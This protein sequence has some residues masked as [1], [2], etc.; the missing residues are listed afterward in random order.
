MRSGSEPLP[1]AP[2][3]L[4]YTAQ[5]PSPAALG[6][7]P[8]LGARFAA[9]RTVRQGLLDADFLDTAADEVCRD[10]LLRFY[11]Q[12]V[13]PPLHGA[14]LQRR[15]GVV[16]HGIA[17][18]LRG[19]DPLPVRLEQ[20]LQPGGA[21]F[22]PGLGPTFWSAIAQGLDPDRH[23]GWTPAILA[24]VRRLGLAKWAPGTPPASIYGRLLEVYGRLLGSG[25]LSSAQQV[26]HFLTRV[27]GT[28]GRALAPDEDPAAR[29]RK[30]VDRLRAG[31][32][33]REQLK[34]RGQAIARGQH[35][36]AQALA[37]CDG[38]ALLAVLADADPESAARSPLDAARHAEALVLWIGR[39]WETPEAA[40][41]GVL[42][43]F[44]QADPVPG[45]GLWLPP[46]VLHLRDP[47]QFPPWSEACRAGY[48][49]LE[50]SPPIGRPAEDYALY[51]EGVAWLRER[52]VL[53]PLEVPGLLMGLAPDLPE[54]AGESGVAGFAGFGPDTFAFLAELAANNDRRWMAGQRAR[55]RFSV[56][57]P[58]VELCQALASRYIEPVLRGRHGWELD[59]EARPGHA[60]TSICKNAFG[61]A[62]PYNSVLWITF[63]PPGPRS[64]RPQ[65]FVRLDSH[66]LRFG[67]R[68]GR[69]AKPALERLRGNLARHGRWVLAALQARGALTGCTFGGADSEAGEPPTSVEALQAWAKGKSCA[70][71]TVLAADD[72]LLVGEGLVG[73]VL[74]AFD[75]LLPLLAAA[76]DDDAG[77]ALQRL[78]VAQP[79]EGAYTT[80]DFLR[81]TYLDLPWLERA[82]GLLEIKKQLILQGVPGTGKTHVARCLAHLLTAGRDECVRLV[83][84]H[85][86]YTY[87]EFVEGIKVRTVEVNGRHEP[88]YP[89]EEGLLCAFAEQAAAFPSRPHVLIVDEINR[90]NLPRIFGELLYLL[91]YREQAV[92]LPYSRRR[93]QLPGNLY[94]LG[95]MNAAD[96]SVALVDQALRRRFSFLEMA[97]DAGVLAA[98]LRSHPPAAGEEFAARVLDLFDKLNAKLAFELGTTATVGHSVFM[99][100]DLDEEKLRLVWSHHVL[101]LVQEHVGGRA[102]RLAGYDLERIQA[103]T[104]RR[105]KR[106]TLPEG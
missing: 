43:A 32:G 15:A 94:L 49:T 12:V 106:V 30:V 96:R 75:R 86:A 97:P 80:A 59:T 89:V 56:R 45:A 87:E 23:P 105:R 92:V 88:T 66:G 57:V 101:P 20:C 58:L 99:V 44:W 81:A 29:W 104:P 21:Y 6:E 22:V 18:L 16:R 26:D 51:C 31:G 82:R 17:A 62:G 100:P 98:W 4:A 61:R 91:E 10:A 93:F 74:L 28:S 68:L 19:R 60:L 69:A 27:A 50:D 95:T 103:E 33:L 47:Q 71:S 13:L 52:L 84:F 78:G 5:A 11:G 54:R 72:Q 37:S 67:L 46:A 36:L 42:E 63:R 76:L 64:E 90:G 8:G 14:T 53:H 39:L 38:P 55:Y 3:L 7:V 73:E 34:T 40:L 79:E 35:L 77:P 102:D 25:A 48:A 9:I 65:L 83:Q 85:P 41:P 70:V 24:G 1:L 2:L